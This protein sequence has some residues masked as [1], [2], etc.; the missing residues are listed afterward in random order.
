LNHNWSRAALAVLILA[1]PHAGSESPPKLVQGGLYIT[2]V[3][4]GTTAQLPGGKVIVTRE[5]I[6]LAA[7]GRDFPPL[8][9][10]TLRLPGGIEQHQAMGVEQRQFKV[11]RINGL[12]TQKVTPPK[13][14]LERIRAEQVRVSK[15]R[16][17]RRPQADF[18]AGFRWPV[19]GPI[20]GVYGSQRILNG[21][22]RQPHYGVDVGVPTGTPVVA[23]SPGLV[24]LAER[25]LYFSGGT[26][27]VDHGYGL[28]STFL[29]LSEILVKVGARVEQ[30]Q[31]IAKVGATGRVTGPHLDW[32]MNLEN[33]RIDPV[34][35]LEVLPEVASSLAENSQ[36]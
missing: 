25:D 1:A 23:P 7:V 14:V 10:L 34:L 24:T 11:Q 4:P 21:E 16:A 5:G 29:H 19:E 17:V 33:V 15:A 12:P 28:S 35:V 32:R 8:A 30:G 3:P 31:A 27:I 2:Q 22:P 13:A 6:L 26:L 9:E 18:H 36:D 20:T